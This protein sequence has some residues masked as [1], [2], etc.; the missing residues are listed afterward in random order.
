MLASIPCGCVLYGLNLRARGRQ[1]AGYSAISLGLTF[2]LLLLALVADRSAPGLLAALGVIG[3]INVYQLERVPFQ[4][5]VRQGAA[6]AKWWPPALVLLAVTALF[7][8][9]QAFL[10]G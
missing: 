10:A 7:I 5:A 3:A 8:S 6:P 2:G 4:M 1:V 9:A